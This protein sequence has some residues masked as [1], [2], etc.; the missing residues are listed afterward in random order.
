ELP[1]TLDDMAADAVALLDALAIESAHLVGVSMGGMIAQIIAATHPERAQSLT[2]IMAG[3]G[4]PAIRVPADPARMAAVPPPP[5]AADTA[6]FTERQSAVWKALGSPGH[7]TGE[8][9]V[10]ARVV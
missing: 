4:N 6:A 8:A 3:S 2:P 1:Y 9:E 5:P 10:R 7:P